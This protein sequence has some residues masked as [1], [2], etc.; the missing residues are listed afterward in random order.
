MST[1]Q[2]FPFN[3]K[4]IREILKYFK[5]PGIFDDFED[6]EIP[7]LQKQADSDD[8]PDRISED[9]RMRRMQE[10]MRQ[11]EAESARMFR[12][13]QAMREAEEQALRMQRLQ[14][15]IRQRVGDEIGPIRRRLERIRQ[16]FAELP[17]P[18][19]TE[20]S[21]SRI[22]ELSV[23]IAGYL[24]NILD[25]II[26]QLRPHSFDEGAAEL[27]AEAEE[28][29]QRMQESLF[30]TIKRAVE[31]LPRRDVQ[32]MEQFILERRDELNLTDEQINLL[33]GYVNVRLA[34]PL[35]EKANEEAEKLRASAEEAWDRI[36]AVCETN[37]ISTRFNSARRQAQ[38]A[39]ERA[40]QNLRAATARVQTA[41]A[42]I[43]RIQPP[44]LRNELPALAIIEEIVIPR[45]SDIPQNQDSCS[46]AAQVAEYSVDANQDGSLFYVG[47]AGGAQNEAIS[48]ILRAWDY[49]GHYRGLV[50]SAEENIRG[51]CSAEESETVSEE[52][53]FENAVW[54]DIALQG[55]VNAVESVQSAALRVPA[56][57]LHEMRLYLPEQEDIRDIIETAGRISEN[58]I[59]E[60]ID[61][62][63]DVDVRT[64]NYSGN[65]ADTLKP[66]DRDEFTEAVRS[67]AGA[68]CSG[69]LQGLLNSDSP[70]PDNFFF[71]VELEL[72]A[73][74]GH[75]TQIITKTSREAAQEGRVNNYVLGEIV[76]SISGRIAPPL[77]ISC[78]NV[79]LQVN[80]IEI[81]N[82]EGESQPVVQ[83]LVAE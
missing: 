36:R 23:K 57:V 53:L 6:G 43:E 75:I 4:M 62:D 56:S 46:A 59:C 27:T 40:Q 21:I 60:R 67:S 77:G 15:E 71:N 32:N 73:D 13:Q 47:D 31:I 10:A 66:A 12:L 35:I 17:D 8:P 82:A 5:P 34:R 52:T 3:F 44:S 49:I 78:F 11:A 14:E 24:K 28:L 55:A 20:L 76:N 9:E 63:G 38:R 51:Y 45:E 41:R 19:T 18:R 50:R 58:H 64:F 80:V 29:V 81:E 7:P 2:A 22:N 16:G 37:L 42:A 25:E 72:I 30:Y 48:A 54:A 74:Q 79:K 70:I 65:F 39:V 26:S 83:V 69:I 33:I 61:S 68:A 1:E